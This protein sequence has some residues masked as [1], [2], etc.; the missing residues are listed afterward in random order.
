MSRDR[1]P[2]EPATYAPGSD[3]AS[4]G[5]LDPSLS[6]PGLGP[7]AP[8]TPTMMDN[9]WNSGGPSDGAGGMD[10]GGVGSFGDMGPGPM[11]SGGTADA[12]SAAGAMGE[13]M[14]P[15]AVSV[16][17]EGGSNSSSGIAR[18]GESL[19]GRPVAAAAVKPP[20]SASA[21]LV[22]PI[23]LMVGGAGAAYLGTVVGSWPLGGLAGAFGVVGALF[24]WVMLRG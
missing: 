18:P 16:Q 14:L 9:P 24:S 5:P 4:G 22:P 19:K 6:V 13:I 11:G 10:V 1:D 3:Y 15:P 12:A 7:S 8:D 23:L 2:N 20:M 21:L 17:P